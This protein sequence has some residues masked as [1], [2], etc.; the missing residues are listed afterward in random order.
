MI[1]FIIHILCPLELGSDNSNTELW[2]I[3]V[4]KNF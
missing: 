1:I 2:Y 4:F 3:Q